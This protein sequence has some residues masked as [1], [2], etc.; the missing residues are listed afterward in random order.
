MIFKHA[1]RR[2][3]RLLCLVLAML[4]MLPGFAVSFAQAEDDGRTQ[5]E[6]TITAKP[7]EM[8]EPGDVMLSFTIENISA[9][10]AQN[11][12]LSSADGLLSEPVGE[13]AAGESQS[14]NRQHSVSQAEL[15]AG[16]I[17]YI[18]SH[19]DPFDPD[20]KVNYTVAAAIGRSDV[21]PQAELTR[22]VSSRKVKA[23]DTLVITYRIRN[24][25]NVV[26]TNL[27]VQDTLG[28][29]TG[30]VD[31]LEVGKSQTLISRAVMDEAAVS[32]AV[33]HYNAESDDAETFTLT[34]DDLPISIVK[35]GLVTTF[36]AMQSPFAKRLVDAVLVLTNTG[37]VDITNVRVMDDIYGGMVA[38][39]VTVAAGETVEIT[40]SYA[41]RGDMNF[42]WSLS[43]ATETG[44]AISYTTEDAFVVAPAG[45][46]RPPEI[47][48]STET[49][50]IRRSGNV[51][52]NVH[53]SNPGGM[54]LQDVV[55]SEAG[56][57][58]LYRFAAI[59]AEGAAEREFIFHVEENTDYVFSLAY[60]DFGG[61]QQ[62]AYADAVQ[63]SITPGGVL[64][65]GA[66]PAFIEFTGNSIKIGGSRTFAVL[67]IAGLSVLLVLI[68]LLLIASRRARFEKQVRIAAEKQRRKEEQGKT[69]RPSTAKNSKNKPK[70]RA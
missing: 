7:R 29:F 25:G 21:L 54:D 38:D 5:L 56:M 67:L 58:E 62:R 40:R 66:S 24:T 17:I 45:E 9:V 32:S 34:L 43:G 30:R 18:L 69:S 1:E 39:S 65:E 20:S 10:D 26:L 63:V 36:S 8:V 14:F 59:P 61:E 51:R 4:C 15:D 13:L 70:G 57:G 41:L 6:I 2:R 49:P 35:S 28:D 19:D 50:R 46:F 55:L 68:I 3:K 31:R 37:N 64:P 16:E 60:T 12:Y 48:V 11:V 44:E 47:R 27:R 22:Q 33:L 53:V 52:M 23:G 42:R